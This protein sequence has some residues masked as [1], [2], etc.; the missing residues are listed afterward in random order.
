MRRLTL[1]GATYSVYARIVRLVL[2]EAGIPYDLVEIDIFDRDKV[3]SDYAEHHP[4]NRIPALEHDGFRLFETD[5]IVGYLL[6]RFGA[7]E[8]IPDEVQTRARMRQLMRIADNYAYRGLVWGIYIEEMERGRLGRLTL[9][10]LARA[11][12]CLRVLDDLS[13]PGFLA[14]QK[15]T[16]A[17]LWL[18][19]MLAYLDLAPAGRALLRDVPKLE[20]WLARMRQRRA[21]VATRF[22]AEQGGT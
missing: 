22:P 14:G 6:D 7:H 8:L 11:E 15:L 12:K 16:L 18:Q 3:P 13:T 20:A 19:P 4:F 10:E 9:D 21:V 5:A 2:E 17:D 1:F